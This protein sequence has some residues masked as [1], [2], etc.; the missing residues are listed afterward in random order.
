[1]KTQNKD[2]KQARALI[3]LFDD[4]T[5]FAGSESAKRILQ[6]AYNIIELAEKDYS[7]FSRRHFPY[8]IS[9]GEREKDGAFYSIDLTD[10]YIL[11]VITKEYNV[12]DFEIRSKRIAKKMCD[13]EMFRV[14]YPQV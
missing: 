11:V 14:F 6:K 1:M 2:T 3:K 4:G 10:D 8:L 13:D 5:L 12:V 7:E 9:V